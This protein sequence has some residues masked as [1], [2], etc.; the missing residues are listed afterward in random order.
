MTDAKYDPVRLMLDKYELANT[1]PKLMKKNNWLINYQRWWKR[2]SWPNTKR[3]WRKKRRNKNQNLNSKQT[4]NQTSNI[5][6]SNGAGDNLQKLINKMIPEDV[7]NNLKQEVIKQNGFL[8]EPTIA[9]EISQ[10]LLKHKH[11]N[12]IHKHG[13]SKMNKPEIHS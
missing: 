5:I 1:K 4:I 13:N 12:D 10:L 3:W 2:I 6:S 9:N 8:T 7:V 11:G